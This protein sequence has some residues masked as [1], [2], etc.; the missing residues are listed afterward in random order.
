MP[1][2]RVDLDEPTPRHQLNDPHLPVGSGKPGR[3]RCCGT[4][5]D[6]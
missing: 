1:D 3:R 4:T 5:L 2:Q 6:N